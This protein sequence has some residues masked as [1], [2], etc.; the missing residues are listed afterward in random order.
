MRLLIRLVALLSLLAAPSFAQQS[1]S[2]FSPTA[3]PNMAAGI[4]TQDSNGCVIGL[5][6]G[7]ILKKLQD[8]AAILQTEDDKKAKK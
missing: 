5:N 6:K 1:T 2:S 7:P 8:A 4:C 3:A